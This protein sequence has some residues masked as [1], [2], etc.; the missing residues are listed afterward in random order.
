LN[1]HLARHVPGGRTQEEGDIPTR[2]DTRKVR[3]KVMVLSAAP[4][5]QRRF[6]SK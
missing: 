2:S 5:L 6:I 1:R 4:C 3:I